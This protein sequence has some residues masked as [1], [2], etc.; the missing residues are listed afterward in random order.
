MSHGLY[1]EGLRKSIYSRLDPG[2]IEMGNSNPVLL[3]Q[4]FLKIMDHISHLDDSRKKNGSLPRGLP[5]GLPSGLPR[6]INL[7]FL[8]SGW[9]RAEVYVLEQIC[10]RMHKTGI[11]IKKVI[12]VDTMYDEKFIKNESNVLILALN[13]LLDGNCLEKYLLV[14]DYNKIYDDEFRQ[15][16]S[17]IQQ[18]KSMDEIAKEYKID[19]LIAFHFQDNIF[20]EPSTEGYIDFLEQCI[21]RYNL[22]QRITTI[23]KIC[24]SEIIPRKILIFY[25]KNNKIIEQL[26]PF[27]DVKERFIPEIN[28]KIGMMLKDENIPMVTKIIL[29]KRYR[30]IMEKYKNWKDSQQSVQSGGLYSLYPKKKYYDQY[31]A[32]KNEYLFLH[33]HGSK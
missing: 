18:K 31:I 29:D 19:M 15:I 9:A 13:Q 4:I 28:S 7:C 16:I 32:N 17:M 30:M 2:D 20:I 6:G 23:N 22:Y 12:F 26:K 25:N 33:H 27:P 11:K 24:H 5:R 21:Q 1:S 10:S 14:S 3:Y 8:S